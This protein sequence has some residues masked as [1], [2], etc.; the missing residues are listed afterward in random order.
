MQI[1]QTIARQRAYFATGTTRTYSHRIKALDELRAA[2]L[3]NREKLEQALHA[4]LHKS[5]YESY[6]TELGLTMEELNYQK[7]HLRKWMKTRRHRSALSQFPARSTV[8]PE[9]YGVVLVMAPWNYP[10]LLSL[11]PLIGAI[12]AGNCAILKPSAY[13]SQTSQVLADIIAS[14]FE[15]EF[16]TVVQGGRKENTDLL[17]QPFD[18]IFFTGSVAVGKVVMEAAAK[19]LTPVTLELGGKSPVIVDETADLDL[20]A[21]R[22]VFGKIINAGQTCIAPDYVLVQQNVKEELLTRIATWVTT[23]LGTEPLK[24]PDY[25]SIITKARFDHLLELMQGN[26]IRLGGES[27]YPFIAPTVLDNVLLESPVMQEEIFGPLLPILTYDTL[28][29]AIA[30]VQARPKPLAL[31]LFTKDTAV[32]KKI[33]R[34]ISFGGGCVNDTIMHVASLHVP[35]GG[36][37]QSGMGS[38]HGKASFETFSHYKTMLKKGRFLDIPV[39]YHPYKEKNLK[40]IRRLLR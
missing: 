40:L 23:F 2:I 20:A 28:E 22:I 6:M 38:Y 35:F 31:Y 25:P 34:Q 3:G 16:V 24:N 17:N 21:K 4:D 30:F 9:P 5:T 33:L 14:A 26:S 37:G 1:A 13:A 10:V 39:R 7:R 8:T 18:Y 36:V 11:E 27:K 19:N 29:E 15:P 32:E 12:A